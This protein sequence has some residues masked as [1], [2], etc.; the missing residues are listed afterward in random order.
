MCHMIVGGGVS[1]PLVGPRSPRSGLLREGLPERG[2]FGKVG[3]W[4][5]CALSFQI[6]GLVCPALVFRIAQ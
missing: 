3:L 2:H 6:T 1:Q 5:V 4:L